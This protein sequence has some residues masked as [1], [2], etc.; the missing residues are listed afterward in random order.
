MR[1]YKFFADGAVQLPIGEWISQ[2]LNQDARENSLKFCESAN[3]V[4]RIMEELYEIDVVGTVVSD[5][6]HIAAERTKIVGKVTLWDQNLGA[7]F[8]VD[9]AAHALQYPPGPPPGLLAH[10]RS[11]CEYSQ[12]SCE[13]AIRAIRANLLEANPTIVTLD[14][15][16][17]AVCNAARYAQLAAGRATGWG[18]T[19]LSELEEKRW[20]SRH[21]C[22]L[23]GIEY[24]GR[25]GE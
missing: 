16:C 3:L 1:F 17:I 20:Q 23:L 14:S 10:E 11:A 6:Y 4:N 5:G 8:A 22:K 13:Y 21:L 18:S 9:C 2:P 15:W 24:T 7:R 25:L 12:M 19:R